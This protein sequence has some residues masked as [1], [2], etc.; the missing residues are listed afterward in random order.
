MG[1]K[2]RYIL[3]EIKL[4]LTN[5]RFLLNLLG[6]L[7]FLMIVI[8]GVLTWLKIYTNHGQQLMLTDYVDMH[9]SEAT[10]DA[11]KNSF[12]IIVN[13]S[14]HIVGKKGGI[15]QTQNPQGG[16]LVKEKRKIYVR[17]T[18]YIA[19]LVDISDIALYGQNFTM[20][21]AALERKGI[22]T[23]VVGRKFERLA[24]NIILEVSQDGQTLISQSKKPKNPIIVEKGS[25][26][27]FIITTSEGGTTPI[28]NLIGNP[29]NRAGFLAPD[30]NIQIMNREDVIDESNAIIESQSPEYDG[31]SSLPHGGTIKVRVKPPQ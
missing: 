8:W 5:K 9:I 27:D 24:P 2:V 7:V 28:P 1:E 4:F 10:E 17:I 25:T 13:D 23:N 18:K 12:E 14:V 22:K 29:I 3:T 21:K 11:K 15:I 20:K 31:L 16:A 26:L 30:F 6:I 19:D